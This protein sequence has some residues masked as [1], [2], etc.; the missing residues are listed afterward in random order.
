MAVIK[1]TV[2]AIGR[3]DGSTLRVLWTPVTNADTC[4]AVSFPECADKSIQVLGTFNAASVAVHGSNDAGT[5]FAAL[6]D[7]G[8]TVI[9][10]SAAGIKAILENTELVKPVFSGGGASQSLSVAMLFHLTNPL[11]T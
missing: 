10:I 7:P 5:T 6:N 8:G 1:P 2:T 9:A 11:R 3:G 4:A